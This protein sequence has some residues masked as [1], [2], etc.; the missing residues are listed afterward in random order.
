[1]RTFQ[2]SK[3]AASCAVICCATIHT[4]AAPTF[5]PDSTVSEK[6]ISASNAWVEIDAQKFEEN[7]K[8]VQKL[9]GDKTKICAVMKANA[10]GHGIDVLIPS[11]IKLNV[12]CVG[13]ASNAEAALIRKHGY[14]G[15]IMRLR[16]ATDDEIVNAFPLNVEELFG[17]FD[18][19]NRISKLAQN[20]KMVINY[21]LALNSGGM[22]RNGMELSTDE[23]KQQ[24][25]ELI[26]LPN[27]KIVGMMTHYAVN[28]KDYVLQKLQDFKNQTGW[29]IENA[30]LDRNSLT[31][32]TANSF[33]TMNIPEAHFDM[34][35]PGS[36][37]YGDNF[38]DHPEYKKLMAFKTK[39]AVVNNYIKG[40]TISY[41][42]TYVLKRNS[43]L[44]NLP[45]GFSDGYRRNFSNH[46]YV[47][48][49]GHRVPVLGLV[50]MNTTLVDVTDFPDITAGDEVV[51]YGEQNGEF[52]KSSELEKLTGSFLA[53]AYTV[54][55]NSN[56]IV[57]KKPQPKSE[58]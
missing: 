55:S 37:L 20:K 25:L 58:K 24:A 40:S 21:H 10:Y 44:A 45:I 47:L 26:K 38:P 33:T 11:I 2:F 32:H 15:R 1:M 48:I 56:P 34:V 30:K 57:L 5:L 54:W 50:T 4:Y 29:L 14:K 18:Q 9:I 12:P 6:N 16:A 31:L 23:G 51:L 17:N 8:T 28:S 46:A 27:L 35:R 49:R 41:D 39:V 52:I 19:A 22:D 13:I 7:I 43:R 3:L 36:I 53:E 42:Q